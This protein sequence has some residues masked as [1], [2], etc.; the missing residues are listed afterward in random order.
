MVF[1][2]LHLAPVVNTDQEPRVFL[3]KPVIHAITGDLPAQV[4][5]PPP[6]VVPKVAGPAVESQVPGTLPAGSVPASM[7]H[8]QTAGS[9]PMNGMQGHVGSTI[10]MFKITR[11]SGFDKFRYF[12]F[13][14]RPVSQRRGCVSTCH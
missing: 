12:M 9:V 6:A 4:E 11:S 10:T 13:D 1:C 2:D 14:Y 3:K 8:T 5:M 7:H